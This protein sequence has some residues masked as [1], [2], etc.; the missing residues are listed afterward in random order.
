[1]S[2]P[3]IR[4]LIVD[5]DPI[6]RE[7][8][9]PLIATPESGISV[10]ATA[11][12]GAEA[13][14]I[15]HERNIDVVVMDVQMPVLDGVG[16]TS[17]ILASG[18]ST[19]VL[20]L[21]TFDDDVFLDSGIA[22]GASGFLLKTTPP[23]E[24]AAAIRTV[25]E[26]GKILSPGPTSRI[27]DRYIH[28]QAPHPHDAEDLDLSERERQVLALLCQARSNQQIGRNLHVAETTVKSHVSAIMRKMGVS[29]RL[30]IVVEAH[31]R[32]LAGPQRRE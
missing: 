27:L 26:G 3:P 32:G 21:T 7:A 28:G 15:V 2:T 4:I 14:N 16:A 8:L 20:L 17:R 25:H 12:N 19:K 10:V 1:M 30:A 9:P 11:A 18:G 5:D 29:S 23:V 13:V 6:V 24:I 31:K 22:A